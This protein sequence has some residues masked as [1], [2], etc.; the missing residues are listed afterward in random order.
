MHSAPLR[1]TRSLYAR[2][3][4]AT[5][6]FFIVISVDWEPAET[7]SGSRLPLCRPSNVVSPR[8]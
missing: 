2:T 6:I 8:G 3:I 5:L 7:A 4:D 1:A